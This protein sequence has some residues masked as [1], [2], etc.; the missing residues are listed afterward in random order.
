MQIQLIRSMIGKVTAALSHWSQ[1]ILSW[2]VSPQSTMQL[3]LEQ[4]FRL[5]A[6]HAPVLIWVANTDAECVYFNRTWLNFTGRTLEQELGHGWAE[7]VHPDD[8][9][10]CMHTFLTAF[11]AREPFSIK[12]RL[13]QAN[14][15][16]CW[17]LDHG[18][19]QFQ[20][21]NQFIGYIGSCT[22]ITVLKQAEAEQQQLLKQLSDLKFALDQSA[23]VATTDA[24]GRIT[25]VN[26][27]FCQVSQYTQEELIGQTHQLINSGHHPKFFF[28][29]LWQTITSGQGWKGEIKNRAKDGSEYWVD[30]VIVPLVDKQDQPYQYMAIQFEITEHKRAEAALRQSEEQNRAILSAIPDLLTVLDATGQF[31][32]F[33]ANHFNGEVIPVANRVEANLH[34]HDV[35]P[36]D[37]AD[38]NLHMIQLA[39][40]TGEMQLFEQKIQFGDIIQF[41]EVR[42]VPYQPN[43]VLCMV[44]N[45]SDR[46]R[47]EAEREQAELALRESETRL[48]RLAEN[49]PGV[50]YR[51]V[52]YADGSDAFPYISP[53]V[54][55]IYGVEAEAVMQQAS[56]LWEIIHPEDVSLVRL[57]I[58]DALK[59]PEHIFYVEH[60][61]IT[62]TGQLKWVQATARYEQ[63]D[64][65]V[66]W[67]GVV[68]DI[69]DRKQAELALQRSEEQLRLA[70]EFGRIAIWDW[71]AAIGNLVWNT[72][73][74]EILGYQPG[75]IEPTYQDWL[76]VVHSEDRAA[77][78]QEIELALATKRDFSIEYRVIW[79]DGT[80]HWIADSGRGIYNADGQVIRSVGVMLDITDRKLAEEALRQSE[81]QYRR[82]VETANEGIWIIDPDNKT[83]FVNSKMAEILG[84]SVEEMM[85]K[86]MFEFMEQTQVEIATRNAERRRQGI[87]EHHDF[88]F[89]HKNGAD[90]WAMLA[91]NPI[92][93]DSG[94]YIGA[95]AMITDI[96]ARKQAEEALRHSQ[97]QLAKAQAIAHVGSWEFDLTTQAIT[98]SDEMFRIYGM[99]PAGPEPTYTQFRDR[100][101][102]DDWPTLEAAIEQAISHGIPYEVEHRI[103]RPDGTLRYLLGKGEVVTNAQDHPIQLMGTGQDITE[104]K[105]V[106]DSL[107][108]SEA[109]QS[110]LIRALP[111]L[112]ARVSDDGVYL[113]FCTSPTF[114]VL[115]DPEQLIGT[116]VEASL[117]PELAERRMNAIQAAL[118]TGELQV[119]EQELWVDGV[120]Q[121]EECRIVVCGDNELLIIGRDITNRKRAEQALQES[122]ERRRLALELTN[123]GSWEFDVATGGAI[124]SDSHYRLMGLTPGERPSNYQTW[125]ERVHP[126][127]LEWVETA[128]A[129]ALRNQMLL[130]LEYRIVHPDGTVRWVLTKGQGIYDQTGQPLRMLGVMMDVSD[131]KQAELALQKLNEELEQ[132]VQ[133]RTQELIQ[134]EQDL[135]TIFNNVYD[136]IFIHDLNGT[137][138]DVNDR[139]LELYAATREQLLAAS[140]ADLSRPRCPTR[141]F[142]PTVSTG[143]GWQANPARMERST[144]G[145]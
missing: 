1:S 55:E 110:A 91:A 3:R 100:V 56:V 128:F 70:L 93:D 15:D 123:T 25:Y 136:A 23:I 133:Q 89:Q 38:Q 82:I 101:H 85:G 6:D 72:I 19:P 138:L 119:Y 114:R 12:Y 60:R 98:W 83:S 67:D 37:A 76:S 112:I 63:R 14:G 8:V 116:H 28:Q 131:R 30:T 106:E 47:L 135:R 84:Y 122:E 34:I 4:Q 18:I 64:T 109:K 139:A 45:I 81:A 141:M 126:E 52:Q 143:T 10:Q 53:R 29:D 111:D 145:R 35:M 132:R 102:P 121:T 107:R 50:V 129:Q 33:S 124:W 31:L 142:I 92:L 20:G 144:L 118:Q 59:H 16:Y 127:E 62:P 120:L 104:R 137:I 113:E 51:Y 105:Q 54:A 46:K 58:A 74:Y 2:F 88:K 22:D 140:I 97:A 71:D 75:A 21:R 99:D 96:T 27:R 130:D 24:Q 78:H 87:K 5:M 69:T 86:S 7:G 90:V 41:E 79:P 49:L 68:L 134:S 73:A 32:T 115:G 40:R 44:R 65:E 95:L 11:Q 61:I 125:R 48:R 108:Q 36:R 43:R 26:D 80:Q 17:V 13:R 103:Y 39:L 66:V 9:Q 77:A 117:P 57:A 94:Q 42:V